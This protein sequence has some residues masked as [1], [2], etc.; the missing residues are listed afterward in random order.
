MAKPSKIRAYSQ[1]LALVDVFPFPIFKTTAPTTSDKIFEVGQIWIYKNGDAR[2]VYIFGGLNSSGEAVWSVS[3][4]GS[5]DL[6]TLQ[7][8]SGGAIV[9]TGENIVIAGGTNMTTVGSGSPGTITLNLNDSI[10]V[11]TSIQTPLLTTTTGVLTNLVAGIAD[12]PLNIQAAVG[13]HVNIILGDSAGATQFNVKDQIGDNV[14]SITSGVT[15][16]EGIDI[17]NATG[18]FDHYAGNFTVGLEN[19]TDEI[20]LG[21][22]TVGKLINIGEGSA[23]HTITIGNDSCGDIYVKSEQ[24]VNMSAPEIRIEGDLAFTDRSTQITMIG[25]SDIDF[26]GYRTLVAGTIT[27]PNTSID[28]ND[29]ILISR[30][31]VNGSSAIGQLTYSISDGASFTITSVQPSSPAV[32]ETNDV[33]I[34]SYFIVRQT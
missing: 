31:S 23:D 32:T 27:V 24:F 30:A 8:D 19:A 17:N 13:E 4:S 5:G 6:E 10:N 22:G 29:R 21:G 18:D 26:I 14:F 11:A 3:A 12:D 1:N 7:G 20:R 33:S 34:V 15:S 28:T 2:T 16:W 9:P 25:G